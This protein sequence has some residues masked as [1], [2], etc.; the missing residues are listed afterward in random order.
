MTRT[1]IREPVPLDLTCN[2]TPAVT[3]RVRLLIDRHL[4]D[5]GLRAERYADLHLIAAELLANAVRETPGR[6][7]RTRCVPDFDAG[8]IRFSVWD[9][10]ARRPEANLP[11][12]TLESLDLREEN[13]DANGGWGLPLVTALAVSCGV[14]PAHGGKWVWAVIKVESE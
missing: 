14:T 2:A 11:E 1:P 7:I 13:F 9:S 12:L 10:S 6:R 4:C 8:V 3:G 5:W